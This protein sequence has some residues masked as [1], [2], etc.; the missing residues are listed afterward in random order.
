MAIP[1]I[2]GC[3]NDT[4][5]ATHDSGDDTDFDAAS[6]DT[7]IDTDTDTDVDTDTDTDSDVD[8][9]TYPDAPFTPGT[10]LYSPAPCAYPAS[11]THSASDNRLYVTCGSFSDPQG[12]A[13]WKSPPL[14]TTGDWS[15]IAVVGG[16]PSHHVMI[17]D[18]HAAVSHTT[19]DGF[20]IVDLAGEEATQTVSLASLDLGLGYDVSFPAGMALIGGKLYLATSNLNTSTM[21]YQPGTVISFD[22]ADGAV[23][24]AS[25]EAHTTSGLNATALAKL[26]EGTLAVLSSGNYDPDSSQASFELCEVPSMSCTATD[27]G[28][29]TA[30]AAYTMPITEGGLMLAAIQ[31]PV[32]RI[33]G[34]DVETEEIV[35]DRE[36][37][38]VGNFI[39]NVCAYWDVAVIS[40]FG[41]AILFAQTNPVEWQ[42]ILIAPLDGSAGPA[43]IV[44][45]T[46]YQ[47][48][49]SGDSSSGSIWEANLSGL[50]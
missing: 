9:D 24:A 5:G 26:D 47:T 33:M 23:D 32:S 11:L 44:G 31:L 46:L 21:E 28:D 42:E 22:Y 14:D 3:S 43:V 10:S 8:T 20:T 19:P 1:M 25:A 15:K 41:G 29:V 18:Q 34:I 37:P 27:L 6:G 7:D 39:S 16:Y 30:Q 38:D 17:D 48:V 4:I 49:T 12:N 35:L 2:M 50:Y 13:L 45:D 40:D 36:M